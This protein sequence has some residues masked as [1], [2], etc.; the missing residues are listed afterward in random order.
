MGCSSSVSVMHDEVEDTGVTRVIYT[1]RA[2]PFSRLTK[3]FLMPFAVAK[4]V[5]KAVETPAGPHWTRVRPAFR[6]IQG[7][8][9][10]WVEPCSG[11]HLLASTQEGVR[12][13]HS[14]RISDA[15]A[16]GI[17]VP[18]ASTHNKHVE[19]Q[20]ACSLCNIGELFESEGQGQGVG[21][22]ALKLAQRDR[23]ACPSQSRH[24]EEKTWVVE[25]WS[26]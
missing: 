3:H 17:I 20:L 23:H 26:A 10:V 11:F 6:S 22:A 24:A 19:R 14:M 4:F 5:Q 25:L 21:S 1:D 8:G 2:S 18:L 15:D 9:M 7:L 13:F 16:S 12:R